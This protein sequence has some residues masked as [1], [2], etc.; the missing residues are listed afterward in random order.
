MTLEEEVTQLRLQLLA[1]QAALEEV[2][3]M[4]REVL[5]MLEG[6]AA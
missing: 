2:C 1:A 4:L 3:T 6:G 5:E